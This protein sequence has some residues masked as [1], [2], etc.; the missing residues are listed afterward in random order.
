MAFWGYDG[1]G[2]TSAQV[3]ARFSA[4]GEESKA[5]ERGRENSP[6]KQ[7]KLEWATRRRHLIVP[8]TVRSIGALPAVYGELGSTVRTPVLGLMP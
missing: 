3:E 7:K 5:M 2:H 4:V 8:P 6:L 1:D